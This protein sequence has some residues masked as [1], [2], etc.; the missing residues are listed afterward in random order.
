MTDNQTTEKQMK[1]HLSSFEVERKSPYRVH[2]LGS[3]RAYD[4][5][6]RIVTKVITNA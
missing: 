5:R 3:D 6:R 2:E 4:L 1:H